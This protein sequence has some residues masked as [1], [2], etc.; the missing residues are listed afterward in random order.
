MNTNRSELLHVSKD[1]LIDSI[2]ILSIRLEDAQK[3]IVTLEE[4][5]KN[6]YDES[7][8]CSDD[9]EILSHRE[10]MRLTSSD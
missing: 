7:N 9:F 6:L 8:K 10:I 2:Q 5:V 1:E 4:E 3:K